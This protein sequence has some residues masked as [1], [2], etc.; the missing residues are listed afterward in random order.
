MTGVAAT[1]LRAW[2]R[3]YGVPS[4]QRSATSY[5]LYADRDI[6]MIRRINKLCSEGMSP[7]EAARTV[8]GSS[9]FDESQPIKTPPDAFAGMQQQIV[10]AVQD[11]DLHALERG[12]EQAMYLSSAWHVYHRVFAPTMREIGDLWHAHSISVAQEHMASELLERS[13][14]DLLRLITPPK[15][16]SPVV[17]ACFADELHTL[18]L[19]GVAFEL[20]R[21]QATPLVLGARTPPT[22]VGDIVTA[23]SPVAVALSATVPISEA[24][25]NELASS[26]GQACGTVPWIVGGSAAES[27]R[28]QIEVNGGVVGDYRRLKQLVIEA[29][30]H[31][32]NS[33]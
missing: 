15:T 18:P 20:A 21:L 14:R 19:Y 30:R 23:I 6:A 5:R 24:R 28:S 11:F 22:A 32:G 10:K 16:Q 3:R 12:L 25:T 33:D 1:T 17:V 4:P 9:E 13:T 26:Y 29:R 27:M 31:H 2:E 8:A 7:S